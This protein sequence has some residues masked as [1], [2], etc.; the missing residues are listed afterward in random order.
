MWPLD[1]TESAPL[2]VRAGGFAED[3]VEPAELRGVA[4]LGAGAVGFDEFDGV[5]T[6]TGAFIG[7]AQSFGLAGAHRRVDALRTAI[8]RRT[9]AGQNR[10]DRI[11]VA[12]RVFETPQADEADTFAEHGAVGLRVEGAAVPRE[13]QRGRLRETHEHEDVV[14]GLDTAGDHEIGAAEV[15]F[16]H[17]HGEGSEGGG[18]GRVDDAVGAAEVQAVRDASGDH[19]AEKAGESVFLPRRVRAGDPVADLLDFVFGQAVFTKGTDPDGTLQ[20]GPHFD[21]K[22]LGGGDADDDAGAFAEGVGELPLGDVFEQL[23]G[24][25]EAEELGGVGG[26]DDVWRHAVFERVERDL[27]DEAPALRVGLVWSLRVGVVVVVDQPVGLRD[28]GELILARD[29]VAPHSKSVGGTGEEGAKAHDGNRLMFWRHVGSRQS[30]TTVGKPRFEPRIIAGAG[31]QRG[32]PS[33]CDKNETC[34]FPGSRSHHPARRYSRHP[35]GGG[36]LART[37]VSDRDVHATSRF[38]HHRHRLR[39]RLLRHRRRRCPHHHCRRRL[40]LR[41]SH[42]TCRGCR[43]PRSRHRS[44]RSRLCRCPEFVDPVG[45]HRSCSGSRRRTTQ[46]GKRQRR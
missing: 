37:P 42:G 34:V 19:V 25:D 9:D 40:R 36:G 44:K 16:L 22:F 21:Q 17:P 29:D 11:A 43:C 7:T 8:R 27:G 5:G 10:V 31:R 3:G 18:A 30:S 24:D 20:A 28:L 1:R 26:R 12:F 32:S 6:V 38:L 35:R 23:F 33:N 41:W 15:Q 13:R 46:S 14:E 45:F 2:L 39:R 4:R